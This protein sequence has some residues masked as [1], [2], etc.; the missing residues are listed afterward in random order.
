VNRTIRNRTPGARCRE[1]G[2]AIPKDAIVY[3][4]AGHGIRHV[5]CGASLAS[6]TLAAEQAIFLDERERT[7]RPRRATRHHDREPD[8]VELFERGY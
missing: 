8:L 5:A 2:E 3:W 4:S 7:R 1:C 6:S